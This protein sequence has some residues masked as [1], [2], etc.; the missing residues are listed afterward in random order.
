MY[1]YHILA[2]EGRNFVFIFLFLEQA[3]LYFCLQL[4]PSI[5]AYPSNSLSDFPCTYHILKEQTPSPLQDI[6]SL[7]INFG[8]SPFLTHIFKHFNRVPEA[9]VAKLKNDWILKLITIPQALSFSRNPSSSTQYILRVK[10]TLIPQ[11]CFQ[12]IW[13]NNLTHF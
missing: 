3:A 5:I 6:R 13:E 11:F 2:D 12:V 8:T 1:D 7:I 9:L 10:R 4:I